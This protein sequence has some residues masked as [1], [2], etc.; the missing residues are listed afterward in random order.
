MS[1][2]AKSATRRA[3][4]Q[5]AAVIAP[6]S[7]DV[8]SV[9]TN[10]HGLG[11]LA[12]ARQ[13]LTTEEQLWGP[14]AVERRRKAEAGL[15]SPQLLEFKKVKC[16]KA[17]CD[18]IHK[19]L[20][21]RS[22]GKERDFRQAMALLVEKLSSCKAV[23]DLVGAVRRRD[24]E[25]FVL[26]D[27]SSAIV[28]AATAQPMDARCLM[29]SLSSTCT[30]DQAGSLLNKIRL[31]YA[32]DTTAI[33][34]FKLG[35]ETELHILHH[36]VTG[37]ETEAQPTWTHPYT[38]RD[39]AQRVIDDCAGAAA[40]ARATAP[41]LPAGNEFWD[42]YDLPAGTTPSWASKVDWWRETRTAGV[43]MVSVTDTVSVTRLRYAASGAVDCYNPSMGWGRLATE[44]DV[45]CDS[46]QLAE[47]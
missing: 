5:R 20:A 9:G 2:R 21:R 26:R 42:V 28:A 18:A 12:R 4:Q 24:A 19:M 13:R 11:P 3:R 41:P 23:V 1:A 30:A 47:A 7:V 33:D 37:S 43:G 35:D 40:R 32:E 46:D 39:V 27:A 31:R 25:L 17:E 36:A 15:L 16:H 6:P 22:H 14:L 38:M 45:S 29:V 34:D 10:G 8:P 44:E